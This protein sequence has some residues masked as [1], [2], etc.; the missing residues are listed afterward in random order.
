MVIIYH[1]IKNKDVYHEEKYEQAMQKQEL[2]RFK[3]VNKE[4]SKLGY[5]LVA[6]E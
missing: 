6:I 4:A 1:L 5:N 2:I 3:R